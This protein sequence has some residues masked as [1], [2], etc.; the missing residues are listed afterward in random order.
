V[1]RLANT[2]IAVNPETGEELAAFRSVD[3]D[4]AE[5]FDRF[6]LPIDL[7]DLTDGRRLLGSI[8]EEPTPLAPVLRLVAAPGTLLRT[9]KPS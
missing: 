6:G 5:L 1:I 8:I 9:E 7:Y 3:L 2:W 4:I